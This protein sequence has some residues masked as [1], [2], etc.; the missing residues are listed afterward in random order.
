MT[1][2]EFNALVRNASVLLPQYTALIS[3]GSFAIQQL[4]AIWAPKNPGK[5]F[6][7]FIA[8]LYKDAKEVKELAAEQ[9]RAGSGDHGVVQA[10]GVGPS[11][12]PARFPDW[13]PPLI[14]LGAGVWGRPRHAP[15]A[16]DSVTARAPLTDHRSCKPQ[17]H[18]RD[19]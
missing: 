14:I 19:R 2:E 4:W 17:A 3:A 7:E 9:L 1:V 16:G 12:R 8:E 5:T 10:T 13:R 11:R 6:E 18:S 15:P